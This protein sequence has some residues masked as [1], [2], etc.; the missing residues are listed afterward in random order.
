MRFRSPRS[1]SPTTLRTMLRSWSAELA[2]FPSRWHRAARIALTTALAAGVMAA[3]QI[4]NPLGLTLVLSFAAPA[5]ALTLGTSVLFLAGA[6]AL[7]MVML[8]VVSAVVNSPVT[9]IGTFIAY[10]FVTSYIIYGWPR[11]GRLW[12]WVQ[13]PTVTSFYLVLFDYHWLGWENAQMFAGMAIGMAILWLINTV[14]WPQ[15]A[16]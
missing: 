7:Q 6:A 16:V 10:T 14:M 2:P 8:A 4:A 13:I 3:V 1:G 9:H 11:L 15:P 12:L 5:S